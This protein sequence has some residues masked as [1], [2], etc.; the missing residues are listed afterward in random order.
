MNTL[1]GLLAKANMIE[2]MVGGCHV[3][4]HEIPIHH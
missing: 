2:C 4:D 3:R 1:K